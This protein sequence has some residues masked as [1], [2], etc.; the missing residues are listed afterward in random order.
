[1]RKALAATNGKF[2][3]PE[4]VAELAAKAQRVISL[5]TQAGEGW[6]LVGEMVGL[7]EHGT[8]NIICAQ[9]FTLT[10]RTTWWTAC[11]PNCAGEYPKANVVL[12]VVATRVLQVNQAQ[13]HQVDGRHRTQER[14]DPR[15]ARRLVRC[16]PVRQRRRPRSGWRFEA[17]ADSA[18]RGF[19]GGRPRGYLRR[20]RVRLFVDASGRR[21]A[22]GRRPDATR[23]SAEGLGG[24]TALNG[25][26]D[27]GG[28]CADQRQAVL[29]GSDC[30]RRAPPSNRT[31][32]VS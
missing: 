25:R 27:L 26:G 10:W 13:P 9:P 30:P 28:H 29:M 3:V 19:C 2:D 7:I 14:R 16:G 23:S 31:Q 18:G 22:G 24:S 11:S 15:H 5:G 17:P 21:S 1:M 4:T 12:Q 8:P 20:R 6:L 32:W